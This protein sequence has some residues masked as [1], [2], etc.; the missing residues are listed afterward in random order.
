MEPN[1]NAEV[2]TKKPSLFGMITSPGVQFER[3]KQHNA[4][5][6]AFFLLV[7]I[8]TIG[9]LA[10]VQVSMQSPEMKELLADD[11][12]GMMQSFMYGGAVL[13][14]VVF[15][16]II[17]FI[18]AGFYKV[19]MMLMGNDATYKQL[20][21]ITVHASIITYIGVILNLILAFALGGDGVVMYTGLGA[22]FE[23]GTT[24]FGIANSIEIFGI[25]GLIVT[26]MGLHIVAGLSKNKAIILMVIFF[27][28]S[29]GFSIL[30]NSFG[31]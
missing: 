5:W 29:V 3:M 21:S 28:I 7:V 2:S 19:V 25:W 15:T 27:I 12:S 9:A 10:G 31:M 13:A 30:G 14:G 1:V 24:L 18:S 26:G 16:P 20:L 8:S 23:P 11:P 17:F 22:L 6:G 4:V